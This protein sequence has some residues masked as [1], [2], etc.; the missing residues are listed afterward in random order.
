MFEFHNPKLLLNHKQYK[1]LYAIADYKNKTKKELGGNMLDDQYSNNN[2]MEM[3]GPLHEDGGIQFKP[4][5]ELEEGKQYL[6]M[7]LIQTL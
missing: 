1:M 4:D 2:L 5:A 3:E 7:L 6:I